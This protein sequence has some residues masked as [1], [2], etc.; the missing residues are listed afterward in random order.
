MLQILHSEKAACAEMLRVVWIEGER[1]FGNGLGLRESF[2]CS[3]DGERDVEFDN[4]VSAEL[5]VVF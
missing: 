1:V 5:E 4:V 3:G 2:L